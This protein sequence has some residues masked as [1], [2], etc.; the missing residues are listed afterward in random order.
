M[1]PDPSLSIAIIVLVP[2]A[3]FLN[4]IIAAILFFLKLNQYSII[5]LANS[6]FSSFLMNDLFSEGIQRHQKNRLESWTFTKADTTFRVT[7]WKKENEF[8]ISY[9]TDPGSSW[10]F[11]EGACELTDDGFVLTTDSTR[12]V[13]KENYL[14]DFRRSGD[15]IEMNRIY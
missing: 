10:G 13:I 14:F 11:I 3:F 12:Y 5:F 1:D 6:F 7:R 4:I 8:S 2:L 15:K 9:S